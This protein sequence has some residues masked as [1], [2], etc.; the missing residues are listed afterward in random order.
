MSRSIYFTVA[1]LNGSKVEVAE[2]LGE[3]FYPLNLRDY[4]SDNLDDLCVRGVDLGDDKESTFAIKLWQLKQIIDKKNK[5]YDIELLKQEK[6]LLSADADLQ[7]K[8]DESNYILEAMN[9][10]LALIDNLEKLYT[11][12]VYEGWKRG[13]G[14]ND[15]QI[16]EL[17]ICWSIS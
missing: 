13:M 14:N 7:T 3:G 12:C 8:L 6:L 1:R 17:A 11:I 9:E 10:E 15:M 5:A 2:S 4:F 16:G